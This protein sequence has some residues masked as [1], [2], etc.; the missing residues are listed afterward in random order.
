MQ[1]LLVALVLLYYTG[2]RKISSTLRKDKGD[3]VPPVLTPGR[4]VGGAN[5]Q[6]VHLLSLD[7]WQMPHFEGRGAQ[8]GAE[9]DEALK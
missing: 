1:T 2:S 3:K 8:E 7:G 6:S 5:G 9:T 4:A